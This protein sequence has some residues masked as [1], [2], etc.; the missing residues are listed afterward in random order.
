MQLGE[1]TEQEVALIIFTL[2]DLRD[3]TLEEV[4]SDASHDLSPVDFIDGILS[5]LHVEGYED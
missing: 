3:A 1:L 5:K 4:M 2:R